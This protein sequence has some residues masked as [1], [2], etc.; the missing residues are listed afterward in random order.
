MDNLNSELKELV[1]SDST[2]QMF[3]QFYDKPF[4]ELTQKDFGSAKEIDWTTDIGN[5]KF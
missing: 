5:E 4:S 2:T 1:I 3:E